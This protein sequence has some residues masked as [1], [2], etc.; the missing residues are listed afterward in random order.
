M[1][2]W[3]FVR[4]S[5]VVRALIRSDKYLVRHPEV[6]KMLRSDQVGY[7]LACRLVFTGSVHQYDLAP[8]WS[9]W[10]ATVAIDVIDTNTGT[11]SGRCIYPRE[12]SQNASSRSMCVFFYKKRALHSPHVHFIASCPY[13]WPCSS[14]VHKRKHGGTD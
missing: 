10:P 3:E 1:P 2:W 13:D 12:N 6:Q 14:P 9:V 5:P 7:T 11:F 4:S 8:E